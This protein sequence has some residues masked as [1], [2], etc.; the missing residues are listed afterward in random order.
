MEVVDHQEVVV[1][2]L[3]NYWLDKKE[4]KEKLTLANIK[5]AEWVEITNKVKIDGKWFSIE[6]LKE[7]R[8]S[9]IAKN[10]ALD[11]QLIHKKVQV[12]YLT[13][14]IDSLVNQIVE[15]KKGQ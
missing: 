8:I 2:K 3:N 5:S 6:E 10:R 11:S 9:L 1:V 13:S 12:K 15:L 4:E 14:T 7:E